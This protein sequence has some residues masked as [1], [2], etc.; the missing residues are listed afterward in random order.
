[1][2][3]E[4][5]EKK[6]RVV[7][8]TGEETQLNQGEGDLAANEKNHTTTIRGAGHDRF[9]RIGGKEKFELAVREPRLA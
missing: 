5:P 1:L 7:I 2:V 8:P 4:R 6:G 3:F 9:S